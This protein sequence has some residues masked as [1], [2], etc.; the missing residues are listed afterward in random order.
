ME[1]TIIECD[2]YITNI[3][4]HFKGPLF[5]EL[6]ENACKN[7]EDYLNSSPFIV[8]DENFEDIL[9][10]NMFELFHASYYNIIS[11]TVR[12]EYV[13]IVIK[14]ILSNAYK[15]I[16]KHIIPKRSFPI[17]Y[18]RVLPNV[19][20]IAKKIEI[21][22]NTPK[23]EQR[24]E[25]WYTFRHNLITASNAYKCF[26]SDK[27]QNEIIY[28]KC[29]PIKP[30][31]D[32]GIVNTATPFHWGHKYEP[33]SVEIYEKKYNT[34][35]EDFGCIQHPEYSFVGAS[36]DGIVVNETSKRFGRMLEIKNPISRIITGIP[37]KMYWVQMQL[38][39]EVCN[40]N[41]CD[42]LETK[43]AEYEN[44]K[45]F[46]ED[47]AFSKSEDGKQKGIILQFSENSKNIYEYAP[48]NLNENEYNIWEEQQM[49][50]YETYINTIYWKLDKFSCVLVLRNKLWFKYAVKDMGRIWDIVLQ[51]RASGYEHRAPI[52]R[53]K[54]EAVIETKSCMLNIQQILVDDLKDVSD[55]SDDCEP[56]AQPKEY[57][58]IRTES[59]DESNMVY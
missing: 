43:F 28:E 57:I 7:I 12:D 17:S 39:M 15:L 37:K 36:P 45:Q 29:L 31:E 4:N 40:L 55:L 42:F 20:S 13:D 51:E 22:R 46:H 14:K 59:F 32:T 6:I 3:C 16:Y 9:D 19:E 11:Q 1:N 5:Y 50:K 58:Q 35:V 27:K 21:L 44:A 41:E 53:K 2:D 48:L 47:G 52:K 10:D 38:Q 30:R 24:T 25:E 23:P 33:L 54:K 26:D 18:I 8:S 49:K 56:K 34:K